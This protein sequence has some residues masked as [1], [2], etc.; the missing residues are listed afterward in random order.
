MFLVGFYDKL[1][2]ALWI[3]S[4]LDTLIAVVHQSLCKASAI[5]LQQCTV[6]CELSCPRFREADRCGLAPYV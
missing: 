2:A 4:P 1:V 6:A 5:F 3:F